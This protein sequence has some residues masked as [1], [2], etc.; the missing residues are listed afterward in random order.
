MTIDALC[1]VVD[2]YGDIGVVYRLA[3][4][5]SALPDPP[6]LRLVVDDLSAF[7]L[8]EPEVDPA[9]PVQSLRGW[10][11]L[12][13]AG[14]D[15]AGSPP[16]SSARAYA[17]AYADGPPSVVLEC[18]ACGRPDWLEEALFDDSRYRGAGGAV[19]ERTVVNLEYLSAE[20]YPDEFHRLPSLTRSSSVRKYMFMPGFTPATGGLI[21]DREFVEAVR[22]AAEPGPRRALR[23]AIAG[24]LGLSADPDRFWALLFGYERDYGT[25]V[26][27]LAALSRSTPT[28]VFAAAG[29]SLPCVVAAWERAGRPFELVRLPFISQR[30]WDRLLAAADFSLVRGEDSLSRAALAGRPFLWHA[31]PQGGDQSLKV[32]GLVE[33]MRPFFGPDDFAPLEAA[34]E[35]VNDRIDDSPTVRG[36]ERV[37][38]MLEPS[39]GVR[40]GFAA[41][42][43]TLLKNGDLAANLMTFLRG[44]V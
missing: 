11:V 41:F 39:A 26:D 5:L 43:E 42:S 8:L 44:L 37:S 35:A 4:A 36:S 9:L 2:N 27:D 24:G 31:Y 30:D 25:I 13:W 15:A 7:N 29:K 33:R 34:F 21:L 14:P 16:G 20:A 32:R 17:D 3:R 19:A 23:A 22:L 18:F 38:A 40:A 1:R 12:D 6:R 28:V 10:T